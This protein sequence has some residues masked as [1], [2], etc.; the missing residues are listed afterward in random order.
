MARCKYCEEGF[1]TDCKYS[2]VCQNC[3]KNN[4]I[5]KANFNLYNGDYLLK[6]RIIV[7]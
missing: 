3:K 5:N 7:T 2:K 6:N 1:E 4:Q